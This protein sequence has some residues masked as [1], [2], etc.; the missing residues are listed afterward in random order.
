LSGCRRLLDAVPMAV[1]RQFE[2]QADALDADSVAVRCDGRLLSYRQLNEQAN[3]LAHC[4]LEH[5]LLPGQSVALFMAKSERCVVALL[6]IL[7]AGGCY[8]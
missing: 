7:K 3:R 1:H 8:V 2:R 5:G 4:L 6:A